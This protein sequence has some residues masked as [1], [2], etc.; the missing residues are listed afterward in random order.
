MVMAVER[1]DSYGGKDLYVSFLQ[2]DGKWTEPK[3]LGND[4]NTAHTEDSPYLA[5][6][7]ETL[8]FSSKGYS[9]FGGADIYISRRLDDTWQNWTDPENLGRDIN[10]SEDDRFFNIPPSGKYAYFSQSN[11]ELDADIVRIPLPI[12]FQPAPVIAMKGR[13]YNSET[14]KPIKSRISY[15]LLPENTE[16]GF[17]MSDSLTGD[18]QIVLPVGS[19]YRYF[20]SIDGF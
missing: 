4:I 8:Y 6:D 2:D 14:L 12:F 13:V 9:G 17:T 3:N 1:F 20:L 16:V 11:T 7:D 15:N 19:S 10:S 5:A 18:Y